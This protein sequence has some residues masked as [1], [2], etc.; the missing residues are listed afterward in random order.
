MTNSEST[1]GDGIERI[2]DEHGGEYRIPVAGAA[3][4]AVLTWQ[5]RTD[6]GGEVWLVD[7]TFT[8]PEA[9]GQGLAGK[10]VQAIVDDARNHGF[11]IAPQCPYVVNAFGKHP[12]WEDV[13]APLPR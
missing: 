9:R 6:A 1:S 11:R 5:R 4:P 10:L 8:P 12:E 3:R 7:H 13:K 2:T